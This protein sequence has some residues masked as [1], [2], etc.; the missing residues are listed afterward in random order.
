MSVQWPRCRVA[1]KQ[2]LDKILSNELDHQSLFQPASLPSR[3]VIHLLPP[4]CPSVIFT[5]CRVINMADGTAP[6]P[7][8]G[9][10]SVRQVNAERLFAEGL[11][12]LFVPC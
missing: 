12:R 7:E 10:L 3:S 11:S 6:L 5:W 4:S 2:E 9:A 1:F 8:R